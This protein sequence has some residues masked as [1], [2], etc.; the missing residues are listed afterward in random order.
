M[1]CCGAEGGQ[2]KSGVQFAPMRYHEELCLL[3]ILLD[4]IDLTAVLRKHACMQGWSSKWGRTPPARSTLASAWQRVSANSPQGMRCS[5]RGPTELAWI[6]KAGWL[7]DMPLYLLAP[8][9][10]ATP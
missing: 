5:R 8:A 10:L 2:E 4:T 3:Y 6:C 7:V 1:R 9:P